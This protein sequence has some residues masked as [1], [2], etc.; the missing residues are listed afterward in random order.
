[1]L[2]NAQIDELR[3]KIVP[4][5]LPYGVQRVVLFGSI[6]RDRESAGD[7]DILVKLKP[8]GERAALGFFTWV[9]IEERLKRELS[10][11][12]DLVSEEGLSPYIRPYADEEKVVLYES[13]A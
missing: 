4:I 12:V 6:V 1:M 2:T 8:P 10:M 11:P 13:E 3:K 7:I 9:K 5:L